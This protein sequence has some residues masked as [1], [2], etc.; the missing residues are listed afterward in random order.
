MTNRVLPRARRR[1]NKRVL[2]W[3]VHLGLIATTAV[4]MVFEPMVLT[5]HIAVGLA[6]AALVA[7]H[8][9]QR[10]RVS[11]SLTRQLFRPRSVAQPSGRLA[12]ADALLA[13]LTLGMLVSGFWDWAIGHPTR[14]RWHALTGVV[15]LV[16]LCVHTV[17]RR[18]RLRYSQV[19]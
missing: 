15:L 13:A 10:R 6:F 1:D 7:V 12:V 2:R 17:N 11:V 3:W 9:Y 4:S 18:H 16:Y 5:I 8:I 19:R 14:I